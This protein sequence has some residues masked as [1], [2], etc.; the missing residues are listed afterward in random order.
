MGAGISVDGVAGNQT[1]Y[2]IKVFQQNNGLTAD[3]IAGTQTINKMLTVWREHTKKD[4]IVDLGT[5]FCAVII[6]QEK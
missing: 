3:G 1:V 5:G 6:M 2:A 4:K